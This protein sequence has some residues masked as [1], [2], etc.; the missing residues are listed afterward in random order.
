MPTRAE[1]IAWAAG[2]FEGEG[3]ITESDDRLVVRL[4]NTD[5]EVIRRFGEILPLGTLYGPYKRQERD[6]F[7]R[8]PLW[9]WI[10]AQENGLDALALMWSWLSERR[11]RRA[12][13][14]TG[15]PFHVFSR[16]AKTLLAELHASSHP[17]PPPAAAA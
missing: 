10:A 8:K 14:L 16:T 2:L 6:G 5:E 15:I 1:E 11:R 7:R 12:G 13:E 3:T 9:V 17:P 4:V